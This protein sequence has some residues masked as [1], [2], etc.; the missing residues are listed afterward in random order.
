MTAPRLEHSY[1]YFDHDA[2]IGLVGRGGSLEAAFV[3][4][5]EALFA[6]TTDLTAVRAERCIHITFEEADVELALVTWLNALLA[7]ARAEGLALGQFG[8][9]RE[10]AHWDGEGWG[11][12]WRDEHERGVEVKGA[13]LTM[14]AVRS[15]VEGWEAR[16]VVDV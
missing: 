15:T 10:G 2:D 1:S 7:A 11:Q 16:C 4:A 5:A 6:L 3:A 13:T 8:L 12:P 9:R 14:L